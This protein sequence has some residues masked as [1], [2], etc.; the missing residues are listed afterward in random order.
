MTFLEPVFFVSKADENFENRSTT[1]RMKTFFPFSSCKGPAK[2]SCN[3]SFG[4]TKGGS[5]SEE[6]KLWD[7]FM[8]LPNFVLSMHPWHFSTIW[9]FMY[10]HHIYS[11][12][13][14]IACCPGWDR[15]KRVRI[16][17]R[18]LKGVTSLLSIRMQLSTTDTIGQNCEMYTP[19]LE[20][21]CTSLSRIA[22]FIGPRNSSSSVSSANSPTSNRLGRPTIS[23]LS[24]ETKRFGLTAQTPRGRCRWRART[25][26]R[27]RRH[28]SRKSAK[29]CN[30]VL[31]GRCR[32]LGPRV[33][34]TCSRL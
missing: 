12:T 17:E 10:G 16:A 7:D 2:S 30:G 29:D 31:G 6:L 15:C 11:A 21:D 22:L 1:T 18:S 23:L 5:G 8:F 24:W 28:F 34:A 33:L 20:K 14:I 26:S 9:R 4:A 13:S 19:C 27:L 25:T 32:F 3:S